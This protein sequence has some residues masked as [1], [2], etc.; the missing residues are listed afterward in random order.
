MRQINEA[1]VQAGVDFTPIVPFILDSDV[2]M[3]EVVGRASNAGARYVLPGAGM[4]L[5]SNQRIRF[6]TLL[7]KNLPGLVERYK[8]LYGTSK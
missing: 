3:R 2:N 4:T 5:R 7:E 6:F 1:G 8:K